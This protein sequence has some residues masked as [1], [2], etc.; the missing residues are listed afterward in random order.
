MGGVVDDVKEFL[1]Y[2][3]E[4]AQKNIV[5]DVYGAL[6]MKS[7]NCFVLSALMVG[8][9]PIYAKDS[10]SIFE[11]YDQFAITS[12]MSSRCIKPEKQVLDKFLDNFHIVYLVAAKELK[13]RNPNVT[14]DKVDKLLT[15]RND[16]ITNFG[17]KTIDKKGCDDADV[18]QVVKRFYVQAQIDFTS[19]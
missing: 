17:F 12:A 10:L 15:L 11:I 18:Q 2:S 5:K 7:F 3:G 4:E 14:D 6:I 9:L 1:G 8:A 13:A 16:E 19:K